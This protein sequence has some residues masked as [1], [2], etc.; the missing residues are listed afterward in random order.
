M[1]GLVVRPLAGGLPLVLVAAACG[2]GD[3]DDSASIRHDASTD[4][5]GGTPSGDLTTLEVDRTSRFPG[6]DSFC[7]PTTEKPEETPK[8]TDDGI[9]ADS[10]SVTQIRVTLE[11]L[12]AL[13]FAIPIGDPADQAERFVGLINDRCGGING[14]KLDLSIVEAPPLAPA[15]Q[16]PQAIAQ[17]ACISATEDHKAV[18]A[19][20][21][22]GG[23]VRAAR[24]AS[25]T[26]TTRSTSP[27]TT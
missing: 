14:R 20:S 2:G 10:I 22:T 17:A 6:L 26:R 5:T 4:K 8:A 18:F 3:D 9:T 16:D 24:R 11:D 19:Y 21:G 13:G 15:G 27:R 1:P 12:E 25:P 23:A 7:E